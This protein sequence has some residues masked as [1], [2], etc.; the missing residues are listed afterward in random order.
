MAVGDTCG[1]HGSKKASRPG[2]H[3]SAVLNLMQLGTPLTPLLIYLRDRLFNLWASFP[4]ESSQLT[5]LPQGKVGEREGRGGVSYRVP[6]KMHT[7][8]LPSTGQRHRVANRT[9]TVPGANRD[10]STSPDATQRHRAD[11]TP[12]PGPE[13]RQAQ[14]AS[15]SCPVKGLCGHRQTDGQRDSVTAGRQGANSSPHGTQESL[16]GVPGEGG[17]QRAPRQ[18]H[19]AAPRLQS[20]THR[21][22]AA[23]DRVRRS[24]RAEGSPPLSSQE[25]THAWC[26]PPSA[27]SV[28]SVFL[29]QYS[30]H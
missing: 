2:G 29:R 5:P 14:A 3:P 9:R 17:T 15:P 30:Q 13:H 26:T 22:A 21:G 8:P 18:S 20:C 11:T 4:E 25:N 6:S 7:K 27:H 10:R 1:S 24:P 12:A 19:W 16:P 28:C 23:R